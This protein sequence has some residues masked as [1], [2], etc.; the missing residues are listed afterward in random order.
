MKKGKKCYKMI[1]NWFTL[2]E[3]LMKIKASLIV[4]VGEDKARVNEIQNEYLKH[5]TIYLNHEEELEVENKKNEYIKFLERDERTIIAAK[6]EIYR[7]F[8]EVVGKINT[9]HKRRSGIRS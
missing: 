1:L 7:K 5:A 9:D 8:N 4:L 6:K 3:N 2:L